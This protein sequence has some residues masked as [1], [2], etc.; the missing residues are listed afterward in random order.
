MEQIKRYDE[1]A[2]GTGLIPSE[3]GDYLLASDIDADALEA[4]IAE[5]QRKYEVT[6]CY[7]HE[8]SLVPK[9]KSYINNLSAILAAVRKQ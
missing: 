2:D 7:N 1:A 8:S 9:L 3:N 6:Q 5:L 4:A